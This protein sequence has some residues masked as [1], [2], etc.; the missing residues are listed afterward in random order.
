MP[1]K[2]IKTKTKARVGVAHGLIE[3]RKLWMLKEYS[4][5]KDTKMVEDIQKDMVAKADPKVKGRYPR[6]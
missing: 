4:L 2:R 1:Q 6:S 5:V 3:G